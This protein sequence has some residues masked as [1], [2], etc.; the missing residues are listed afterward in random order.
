MTACICHMLIRGICIEPSFITLFNFK[1]F[2]QLL[3]ALKTRKC[4]GDCPLNSTHWK[5]HLLGLRGELI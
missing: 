2:L 5:A 3:N 4:Y 1:R